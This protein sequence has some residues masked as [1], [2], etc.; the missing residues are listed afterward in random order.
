MSRA[1]YNMQIMVHQSVFSVSL[2]AAL[3]WITRHGRA[4]QE[5]KP[6]RGSSLLLAQ[7]VSA[8]PSWRL[9]LVCTADRKWHGR[10]GELSAWGAGMGTERVN[11]L[12]IFFLLCRHSLVDSATAKD[13]RA[14]GGVGVTLLTMS[15][16][17]ITSLQICRAKS[18]AGVSCTHGVCYSPIIP[19]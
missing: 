4:L 3:R 11:K 16:G 8:A 12:I 17:P 2:V 1:P 19:A 15:G 14:Y 6:L 5:Y 13:R 7:P 9:M 18:R 10:E